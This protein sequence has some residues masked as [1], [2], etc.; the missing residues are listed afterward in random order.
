MFRFINSSQDN[1]VTAAR[2]LL[3][4]LKVN[5]SD[6]TLNQKLQ[7][8]PDYPS[9]LGIS[10]SLGQWKVESIGNK[11][12]LEQLYGL[13]LPLI[14]NFKNKIDIHF[15][16]TFFVNGYQSPGIYD[17]QDLEYLLLDRTVDNLTINR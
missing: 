9:L 15:T 5:V 17:I 1:V 11:T 3:K 6:T 12:T 14:V 16:P 8:H 13:L 7:E 2:R 10:D 4:L